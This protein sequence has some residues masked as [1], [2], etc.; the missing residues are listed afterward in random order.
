MDSRAT[1][2]GTPTFRV[3]KNGSL[4]KLIIDY[5]LLII[6]Y[7]SQWLIIIVYACIMATPPQYSM[8]LA[9]FERI[10]EN[11]SMWLSRGVGPGGGGGGGGSPSQ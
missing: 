5:C 9:H 8:V 6:D 10:R 1:C 3:A 7:K 11:Q 2:G 4:Y